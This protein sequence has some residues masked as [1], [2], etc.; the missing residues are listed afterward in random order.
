MVKV[1]LVSVVHPTSEV[2]RRY[3][4]LGLGYLAAVLRRRFGPEVEIRI[5][6][7]EVEAAFKEYQPDVVGLRAVS[8][9]Y[10]GAKRFARM[11]HQAGVPV[12]MGGI[13]ITSLP[14]SLDPQMTLAC[15]GEGEETIVQLVELF[16]DKQGFP[17]GDLAGIPG[18]CFRDG[19]EL[20]LTPPRPPLTDLDT[21]PLPARGLLEITKH[22]YMFTSRGCPY[23]CRFCASSAYWDKLRFFSADYV[24]NEIGVLVE[25]YGVKFISFFDDMF[26]AKLS[27]LKEIAE[28]LNRTGLLGR[29]KFSC[30][31]SAPNVT[32]EV[33]RTLK[34][35]NVVSVGLGLESGCEKTLKYLKGAAFSVAKNREAVEILRQH[36]VAAN[37]S[38]VIGSP[39]E[40]AAD[41]METYRFIK[42]TPLNLVDIYVLTPYPGTKIWDHALQRGLVSEDMD[43]EC[44]NVN[45]E[46]SHQEAIILSETMGREEIWEIY[47]KFRRQRF[48]RNLKNIWKHPFLSDLPRVACNSLKERVWRL[49]HARR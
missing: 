46:F 32:A 16:L 25:D 3:P 6:N 11:A 43:W 12:L 2:E 38:F 15:L 37:A 42:E 1:L 30:S 13:H 36:G 44:L 34:E 7:R 31:C 41:M 28:G 4:D 26:I 18:L 33:A 29:V 10:G 14:H 19:Q 35:M 27:R 21:L 45:F 22:S 49:L 17:P 23:R 8:Q 9:N 40:T 20:V 24:V 5:V 39:E 47:K 48:W